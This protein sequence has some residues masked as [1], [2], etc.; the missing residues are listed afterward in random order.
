[1]LQ[2]RKSLSMKLLHLAG[3]ALC[4]PPRREYRRMK[5]R[6]NPGAWLALRGSFPLQLDRQAAIG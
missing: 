4:R 6:G 2:E 5:T 1:M 3:I